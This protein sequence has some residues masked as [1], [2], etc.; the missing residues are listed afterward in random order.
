MCDSSFKRAERCVYAPAMKRGKTHPC[1]RPQTLLADCF[2]LL[3]NIN[4]RWCTT[5]YQGVSLLPVQYTL[6]LKK[7]WC[8]TF[9]PTPLPIGE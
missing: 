7:T 2:V 9:H 6:V 4:H 5:P 1:L 3:K 8:R